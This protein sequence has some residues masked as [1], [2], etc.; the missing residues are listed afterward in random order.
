[1]QTDNNTCVCRFPLAGREIELPDD[2]FV[3]VGKS[4]K[5]NTLFVRFT[6][7]GEETELCLSKE[8]IAALYELTMH[9]KAGS[10]TVVYKK[11][12]SYLD[13]WTVELLK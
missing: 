9:E 7:K 5:D 10:E 4:E 3:F 1:M 11:D 8:A 2:R 13:R 6:N 12:P